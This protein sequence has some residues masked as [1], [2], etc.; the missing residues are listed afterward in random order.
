MPKPPVVIGEV[1]FDHFTDGK[2]VLGGAPFN[3]AWNL[4]GLGTACLFLSAVGD[5][6][7]ASEIRSGMKAW[8]MMLDGLQTNDHSTGKVQVQFVG[9]QPSY[10]IIHPVAFDFIQPPSQSSDLEINSSNHSLLYTGSLA[11][12][13]EVS[14]DTITELI[15]TS[16]LPRFVD[17]NI[18]EPWFEE[19]W[20]D[21]LIVGATWVKLSDEELVRLTSL[22]N[23]DDL[24]SIQSGVQQFRERYELENLLVTA[25]GHGAYYFKKDGQLIHAP[26]PKPK[27]IADTVGAGDSFAAATIAGILAE[28]KIETALQ[29]AVAHASRVCELAGA[30]TD[31]KSFYRLG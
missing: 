5:D 2:R 17:I 3:V 31:D 4:C 19:D 13:S 1:L 18:R 29:N 24:D 21:T 11:F 22:T 28:D 30:T 20:L 27:Q 23:C 6:A 14:R 10:E 8:S 9:G 7:E 25:G 15:Q 16:G 12:R 26:A